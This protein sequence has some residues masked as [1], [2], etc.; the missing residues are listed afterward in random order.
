[1]YIDLIPYINNLFI[2]F[3]RKTYILVTHHVN[4][5]NLYVT[6]QHFGHA[7]SQIENLVMYN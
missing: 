5:V 1:M 4:P 6:V 2:S 3:L 7:I